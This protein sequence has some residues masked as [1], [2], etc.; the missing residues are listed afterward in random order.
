MK[1]SPDTKA[2]NHNY[3]FFIERKFDG[4]WMK[5]S[6]TETNQKAFCDGFLMAMDSLYPSAPYRIVKFEKDGTK[7]IVKETRGHGAVHTN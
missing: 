1:M 4:G 3:T 6:F 5:V 7:K 2:E